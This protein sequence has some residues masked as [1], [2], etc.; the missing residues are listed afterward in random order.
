MAK[1]FQGK[2]RTFEFLIF[3]IVSYFEF[4]ASDF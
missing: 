3:E 4:H 2:F 1:I